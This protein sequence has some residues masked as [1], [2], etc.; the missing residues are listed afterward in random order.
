M[1]KGNTRSNREF[2]GDNIGA[3]IR[4][5]SR[6][7]NVFLFENVIEYTYYTIV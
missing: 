2:K 4:W 1:S 5:N 3:K 7:E 6:I